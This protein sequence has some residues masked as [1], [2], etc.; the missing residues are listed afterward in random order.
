MGNDKKSAADEKGSE[1][2]GNGGVQP[3]TIVSLPELK[4]DQVE[5]LTRLR[6]SEGAFD[7][8]VIVG[9]PRRTSA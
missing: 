7:R 4:Q 5:Y 6:E 8:R 3:K 2:L 9:G 1:A